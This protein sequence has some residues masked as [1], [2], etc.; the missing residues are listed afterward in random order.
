M[1]CEN[2]GDAGVV[3]RLGREGI[4]TPGGGANCGFLRPTRHWRTRT[5]VSPHTWRVFAGECAARR[6]RVPFTGPFVEFST[7]TML[8]ETD[9]LDMA[10][11]R[12]AIDGRGRRLIC[13]CGGGKSCNAACIIVTYCKFIPSSD[14]GHEN[15]P[16]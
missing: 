13:V 8:R 2:S 16:E 3:E 15:V 14:R 4:R 6:A 11:K 12:E 10:S 1:I 9:L 7:G 5:D